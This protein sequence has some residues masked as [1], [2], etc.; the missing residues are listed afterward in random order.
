MNKLYVWA[1][2]LLYGM[3]A[4]ALV[5]AVPATV[6]ADKDFGTLC[7][8]AGGNW[9]QT[10]NGGDVCLCHNDFQNT[11]QAFDPNTHFCIWGSVFKTK[12]PES[13]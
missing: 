3:A 4:S 9:A 6:K 10:Q 13:E 1:K 5:L 12:V 8:E 2:A 7:M 11:D